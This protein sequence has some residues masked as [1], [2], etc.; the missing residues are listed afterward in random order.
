MDD[1]LA[2]GSVDFS[3]DFLATLTRYWPAMVSVFILFNICTVNY[4]FGP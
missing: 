3:D 4:I 2:V 1:M